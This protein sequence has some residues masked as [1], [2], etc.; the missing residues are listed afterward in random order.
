VCFVVRPGP[1]GLEALGV[2]PNAPTR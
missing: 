1:N 2:T